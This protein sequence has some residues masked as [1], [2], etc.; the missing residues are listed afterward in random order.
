MFL[1]LLEVIVEKIEHDEVGRLNVQGRLIKDLRFADD[2][3]LLA[4][5]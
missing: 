3:D 4:E 1:V 2:T 5:T